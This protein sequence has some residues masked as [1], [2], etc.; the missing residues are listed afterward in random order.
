MLHGEESSWKNVGPP[1]MVQASSTSPNACHIHCNW[2]AQFY[3][4]PSFWCVSIL[5]SK[6]ST[7]NI[8]V[9]PC[10]SANLL[11]KQDIQ[12]MIHVCWMPRRFLETEFAAASLSPFMVISTRFIVLAG[13]YRFLWVQERLEQDS[14]IGAWMCQDKSTAGW[15]CFSFQ[16]TSLLTRLHGQV[17]QAFASGRDSEAFVEL[18]VGLL[19]KR[20]RISLR[21][22]SQ[23]HHNVTV[24]CYLT[25]AKA[26]QAQLISV[27]FV[28]KDDSCEKESIIALHKKEGGR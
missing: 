4:F 3:L 17:M 16:G 11:I 25:C 26:V 14:N 10:M 5:L 21:R 6:S 22:A 9:S 13:K 28:I 2:Q 7:H 23:C 24:C 18:P 27:S 19:G 20:R 12:C 15:S 1:T 8:H